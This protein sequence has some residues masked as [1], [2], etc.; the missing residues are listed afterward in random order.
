M[1]DVV[2]HDETDSG[3]NVASDLVFLLSQN[4]LLE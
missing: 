4:V 3:G 2:I 1:H